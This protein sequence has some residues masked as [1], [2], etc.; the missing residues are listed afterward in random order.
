MICDD[1]SSRL[2]MLCK[3]PT[4]YGDLSVELHMIPEN[5]ER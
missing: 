3:Q 5:G 1:L 2:E 4:S